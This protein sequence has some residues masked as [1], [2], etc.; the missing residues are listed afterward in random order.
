M[1]AFARSSKSF[2]FLP[3]AKC[4]KREGN[5]FL[6]NETIY[7]DNESGCANALKQLFPTR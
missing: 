3:F 6:V 5:A 7:A 1:C 2:F 4:F